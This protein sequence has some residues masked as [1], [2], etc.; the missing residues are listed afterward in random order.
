L[1]HEK[2]ETG[3]EQT[4]EPFTASL[5][6]S[7]GIP[8]CR[9]LHS[10]V[11]SSRDNEPSTR[12]RFCFEAAMHRLGGRVLSTEHARTFSSEIEGEQV[13]DSIRIIG[14]SL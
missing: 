4:A 1:A 5:T 8:K 3:S 6:I 12:T 13:E 9:S 2:A 10:P 7:R 11:T 14:K